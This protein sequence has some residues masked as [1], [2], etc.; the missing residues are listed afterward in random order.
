M[1]AGNEPGTGAG[2]ARDIGFEDI[3][4]FVQALTSVHVEILAACDR[5]E[6]ICDSLPRGYSRVACLEMADW[7]DETFPI[8]V[9]REEESLAGVIAR[10]A[11]DQGPDYAASELSHRDHRADMAY[12]NELAEALGE[13]A[14]TES[15]A[16][17]TI[18][19]MMRSFFESVRRHVTYEGALVAQASE[20][21]TFAK[22]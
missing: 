6:S 20:R 4:A 15:A 12:A 5:L 19:Y 1:A 8:L 13:F 16:A 7:L 11:T 3:A 10:I 22:R 14:R 21:H 17:D 9:R 2:G 18:G